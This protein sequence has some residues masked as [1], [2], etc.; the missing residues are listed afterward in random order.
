MPVRSLQT[1][2][3]TATSMP[4]IPLN[5]H[6]DYAPI[7]FIV[8]KNGGGD[9]TIQF[10]W[11]LDEVIES[12]VSGVAVTAFEA[13]ANTAGSLNGPFSAVRIRVAAGSGSA[14]SSFRLLQGG[15]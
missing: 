10:Q 3:A 5:I 15:I 2:L 9:R 13:A 6:E 8:R 7:S 14:T 11:T 12:G 4:W 1:T